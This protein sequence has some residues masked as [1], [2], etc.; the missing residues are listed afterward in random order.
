MNYKKI[1]VAPNVWNGATTYR[2]YILIDRHWMRYNQVNY[3]TKTVA[4]SEAKRYAKLNNL[5]FIR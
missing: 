1:R 3:K 5:N 2:I 4:T